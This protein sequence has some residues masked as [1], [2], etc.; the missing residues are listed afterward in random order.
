MSELRETRGLSGGANRRLLIHLGAGCLVL[1]ASIW[2]S[3][4]TMNPHVLGW[5]TPVAYP[6]CGYLYSIDHPHHRATN[7]LISGAPR[8]EWEWSVLLRRILFPVL[9]YPFM[10]VLGFE[11]GGFVASSLLHIV[12]LVA[13]ALY[14]RAKVGATA[15]IASAWL[16]AT[17]P[18]ISYWAALPYC[19]AAIVP[20][21][22][23]IF[24][25][26]NE[27]EETQR[28]SRALLFSMLLGVLFT[29]YDFL[30]IFGVAALLLL[31]ARHRFRWLPPAA[32]L[33]VAPTALW[34]A[35]LWKVFR[36]P[37][38]NVNTVSFVDIVGSWLHPR[39][40]AT[41]GRLLADIPRIAIDN[42]FDSNFLFLPL[43]FLALLAINRFGPRVR[44]TLAEKSVLGTTALLF[45]FNNAAPPYSGWQMRGDW[46]ARIYQQVFV[47]Y[48]FFGSRVIEKAASTSWR[49]RILAATAA[50]VLANGSVAFGAVLRVPYAG[51]VYWR[52]YRQAPPETFDRNLARYGRR[53]L[54]ICK[55]RPNSQ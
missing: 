12:V 47:V 37:L 16:L 20:L 35:V 3:S 15:A 38:L 41:W 11:L 45:L 52:F 30:P 24:M 48:L 7:M 55:N 1:A 14:I 33:L 32:L 49:R 8:G 28:M 2:L 42:Y 13:V 51:A 34:S 29:A 43:F 31:A 26:L 40:L 54:G 23:L 44:L 21:S 5:P 4:G 50:V 53:P 6:P 19:Y 46:V 9:A 27:L 39:D 10:R 18:G 25:L 22:L 17:Y 36:V